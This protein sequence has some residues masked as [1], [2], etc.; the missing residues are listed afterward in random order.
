MR[1]LVVFLSGLTFAV[2]RLL[3]GF[4]KLPSSFLSFQYSILTL[5]DAKIIPNKKVFAMNYTIWDND[6]LQTYKGST[7]YEVFQPIFKLVLF[8]TI[9]LPKTPTDKNFQKEFFKTSVD[10]EKTASGIQNNYITSAVINSMFKTEDKPFKF[11][12]QKVSQVDCKTKLQVE[13]SGRL[14]YPKYNVQ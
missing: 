5:K 8:I 10:V 14:Q 2:R 6:G 1:T 7:S 11:P 3:P 4:I 9:K 13:L 12:I